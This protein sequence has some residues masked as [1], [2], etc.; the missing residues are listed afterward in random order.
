MGSKQEGA[1]HHLQSP[2]TLALALRL[3]GLLHRLTKLSSS[4]STASKASASASAAAP[5]SRR[6]STH[7][8]KTAARRVPTWKTAYLRRQ[9]L[10]LRYAV[11]VAAN[12]ANPASRLAQLDCQVSHAKTPYETGKGPINTVLADYLAGSSRTAAPP[13]RL[14]TP[15]WHLKPP[16][17][18]SALS[19]QLSKQKS[20]VAFMK[21]DTLCHM[22]RY[23][24]TMWIFTDASKTTEGAPAVASASS[25]RTLSGATPSD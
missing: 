7:C 25:P 19:L 17:T 22:E 2:G 24:G 18:D 14:L 21:A 23:Q 9:R 11:K 16:L 5:S 4:A 13:R 3:R 6:P 10:L 1:A 20:S 12:P 15:P 8:S